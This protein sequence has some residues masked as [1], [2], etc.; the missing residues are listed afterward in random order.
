MRSFNPSKYK[1]Y[2]TYQKRFTP[3]FY[4]KFFLLEKTSIHSEFM[5]PNKHFFKE[6]LK[7]KLKEKSGFIYTLHDAYDLC[8]YRESFFRLL[9]HYDMWFDIFYSLYETHDMM[10]ALY[11]SLKILNEAHL[12]VSFTYLTKTYRGIQNVFVT[13]LKQS[14]LAYI[15]SRSEYPLVIYT[16]TFDEEVLIES[17]EK[18][19]GVVVDTSNHTNDEIYYMKECAIVYHKPFIFLE[20]K[21]DL[22]MSGQLC[23]YDYIKDRFH[24]HLPR[25]VLKRIKLDMKER[26]DLESLDITYDDR[27]PEHIL[28]VTKLSDLNDTIFFKYTSHAYV[29]LERFLYK[30]HTHKDV[31]HELM[32]K[33][34]TTHVDRIIL[35]MPHLKKE[36]VRGFIKI[37]DPEGLEYHQYNKNIELYVR[38]FSSLKHIQHKHISIAFSFIR[39]DIEYFYHMNETQLFLKA[40]GLGAH[41]YGTLLQ[42]DALTYHVSDINRWNKFDFAIIDTNEMFEEVFDKD[43]LEYFEYFEFIDTYYPEV[44]DIH[45]QLNT[46]CIKHYFHG[47]MLSQPKLARKMFHSGF[48]YVMMYKSQLYH[49]HKLIINYMK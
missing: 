10:R 15:S 40:L 41:A 24:T 26:T 25:D 47:Y 1:V 42:T 5:T 27:K 30:F 19:S 22:T 44:K 13:A 37:D 35:K 20:E 29:L 14:V 6:I 9:R 34:S 12:H 2:K 36:F 21:I 23:G 8:K 38:L 49:Y 16:H 32:M 4:G 48:K 18:I 28:S 46:R 33:L 11:V 39:D 31:F 45:Q 43:R 17:D 7:Q 3:S